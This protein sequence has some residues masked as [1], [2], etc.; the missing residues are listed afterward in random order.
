MSRIISKS[1]VD[2]NS[3]IVP[4]IASFDSKGHITPLYIRINGESYKIESAYESVH[5]LDAITFSCTVVEEGALKPL[6]V[7]YHKRQGMWIINL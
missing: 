5:F 6:T 1:N 7:S 4:V 3:L 2:Y